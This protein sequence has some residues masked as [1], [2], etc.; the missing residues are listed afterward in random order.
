MMPLHTR[1]AKAEVKDKMRFEFL[2]GIHPVNI[3]RMDE[4]HPSRDNDCHYIFLIWVRPQD[5]EL[6][7]AQLRKNVR[8]HGH[9]E[10]TTTILHQPGEGLIILSTYL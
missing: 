1:L 7:E 10:W 4:V 5:H 6:I 3:L 9:G 8:K 2:E